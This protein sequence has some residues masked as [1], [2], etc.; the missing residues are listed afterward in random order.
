MKQIKLILALIAIIL[1]STLFNTGCVKDEPDIPPIIIPY[2]DFDA[3]TSIAE[4]KNS[5]TGL[6]MITDDIIIKGI[7]TGNDASGNLYKK[8]IIQDET[9]AVELAID[10]TNLYGLYRVGQLVYVK[11]KGLFIGDYN[12]LIQLGYIYDGK[13]GRM[14]S[15]M[16]EEHIFHDSLPGPKPLPDTI[17]ISEIGTAEAKN[18]NVSKLITFKNVIFSDPGE[19]FAIQDDPESDATNRTLMDQIGN[20]I[21]VRT[22]KYSD[23][24]SDTIPGGYGTVTGILSVFGSDWQ[25]TLRDRND[26]TGFSDTIPPPPGSGSGTFEDPY[27]VES[28]MSNTSNT[29]VWVKGFIVGVYET[30]TSEFTPNF[31]PPFTTNTNLLIAASANE[32]NLANC[33]PVQLPSGDIRTA[34]NLVDNPDNEGKEVMVLGTL[35]AY[36]SQPGVKNLTGYWLDGNGII[37]ATGF[38]TEEFNQS[39]G[40]FTQY[41]VLGEQVWIGQDYDDG[42]VT[43]TGYA[44]GSQFPNED[45]LISP[46]ISLEGKS[47]VKMMFREA[48][49]YA[50]NINQEAK[51]FISTN[52]P[53]EGDPNEADWTELTGFTRSTGNTWTFVNTSEIDLS[54]Y[55]GQEIYIAFKYTSTASVAGTWEISRLVLTAE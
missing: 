3:N 34:L 30:A 8:L 38:F 14:P 37:P 35:E 1:S 20:T 41:N 44:S 53:G 12:N 33:L 9:A 39:L 36:F 4:L 23:F 16:I 52:Y 50:Q 2:V 24:A 45:W 54:G 55:D 15:I 7:I 21:I 47:N 46:L 18:P 32:T 28:G 26:V 27:D 29:P 6:Q 31:N 48:M 40:A 43:M 25:L 19:I 13:I 42:C 11:C 49:N 17:T 5:Y 51:V 22:S 10:K